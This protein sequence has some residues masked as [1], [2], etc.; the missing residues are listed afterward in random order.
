M[1][2]KLLI[3]LITLVAFL[4]F[5]SLSFAST[6]YLSPGSANI[7]QGTIRSVSIGINTAGESVNGVSAY[8]SYPADKLE[9]AYL[10]YGSR[11][12]LAAE[13]TYGGGSIRISR[14]SIAGV[15]GNVNI[16]TIGFKGKSLG[17]ATVAFV[18]GSA[19]PRTSDSSDS[20]NLGGSTGGTYTVVV[21]PPVTPTPTGGQS[22]KLL[23]SNVKVSDISTSAA[24]ISWETN[25]KSDS[26]VEYGLTQDKYFLS[27]SDETLSATHTAKLEGEVLTPGVTYHFRVKSKDE[28]DK[29]AVSSNYTFQ[30]KGYDVRIRITDVAN[31][32]VV[33]TD[34]FIYS[35]PQKS[36]TDS[37]GEV[38]FSN[39]TPGKHLVVVKLKGNLDKTGEIDVLDSPLSQSFT[40]TVD[41][42]K[43]KADNTGPYTILLVVILIVVGAAVLVIWKRRRQNPPIQQQ[44]PIQVPTQNEPPSQ[45]TL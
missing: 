37:N 21:P 12:D 28:K 34:V 39:V 38:H 3:F 2:K 14:G 1:F 20:L 17:T 22:A 43:N 9:V 30:L 23:I 29:E 40:L 25:E 10:S 18:G 4:T 11:F 15:V 27:L 36:R 6:L 35:D 42:T 33:D 32:P 5:A 31:N 7:P 13:G 8:L 41:T 44:P 24:T 26:T 45:T 16:A 19:A